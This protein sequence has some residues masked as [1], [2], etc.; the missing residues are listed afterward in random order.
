M[1]LFLFL[2]ILTP[3]LTGAQGLTVKKVNSSATKFL[4]KAE[5]KSPKQGDKFRLKDKSKQK[6]EAEVVK[7]RGSSAVL[8]FRDCANRKNIRPGDKFDPGEPQVVDK[9]RQDGEPSRTT[10]STPTSAAAKSETGAAAGAGV[11]A[12]SSALAFSDDD[13]DS[14]SN[15][16]K[17]GSDASRDESEEE[18]SDSS[19][20]SEASGKDAEPAKEE[21]AEK[22]QAQ[23]SQKSKKEARTDELKEEPPRNKKDKEPKN[24]ALDEDDENPESQKRAENERMEKS[25]NSE[26]ETNLEKPEKPEKHERSG[27]HLSFYGFYSS[28]NRLAYGS[29][30]ETSDGTV[31]REGEAEISAEASFGGGIETWRGNPHSLGWS[32]G[33]SYD[34]NRELKE[35]RTV[36]DGVTS[37]STYV[38]PRPSLSFFAA[39]ANIIYTFDRL[40]ISLGA[41]H[42][43]PQYQHEGSEEVRGTW[44]YQGGLGLHLTGSLSLE[45]LYRVVSFK[46]EQTFSNLTYEYEK[47]SMQG[48]QILLKLNL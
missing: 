44:G 6:C 45:A 19:D 4:G 2:L 8:A 27:Q 34:A 36:L 18:S 25:R 43:F 7:A 28:A 22:S 17:A 38:E 12:A 16:E 1:K 26:E 9:K 42:S 35:V 11:L 20:S 41:N 48:A 14:N 32:L 39:Y 3:L 47:G 15:R 46:M 29:L 21:R 40:Y 23:E 31:T 24:Q 13:D 30:K 10:S 5:G 33:V 37:S